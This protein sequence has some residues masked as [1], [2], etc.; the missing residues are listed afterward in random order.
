MVFTKKLSAQQLMSWF[1]GASA[2]IGCLIVTSC[3]ATPVPPSKGAEQQ[4]II[5]GTYTFG[6]LKVQKV[7]KRVKQ[8]ELPHF[9]TIATAM[10]TEK[11]A[12]LSR[13]APS[14]T[15]PKTAGPS[16]LGPSITPSATAA[17]SS[18]R[19]QRHDNRSSMATPGPVRRNM[20]DAMELARSSKSGA[21]AAKAAAAASRLAAE[22]R[23]MI[24][25]GLRTHMVNQ[26]SRL[27]Q[28][29]HALHHK[30]AQLQV[31]IPRESEIERRPRH[32]GGD[33]VH[34]SNHQ[35][36][37]LANKM[38]AVCTYYEAIVTTADPLISGG[39]VMDMS[40]KEINQRAAE[41]TALE[42]FVHGR[43]GGPANWQT[44]QKWER[45]FRKNGGKFGEG[46]KGKWER[47]LVIDEREFKLEALAF[48]K[49]EGRKRGAA[50]MRVL[51]FMKWCNSDQGLF[52]IFDKEQLRKSY[53]I[54]G[55]ITEE[56]ARLYL[57]DLGCRFQSRQTGIIPDLY[58]ARITILNA[59]V[60]VTHFLNFHLYFKIHQYLNIGLYFDGHN[61]E[62]V[63]N[64]RN[65]RFLPI[66]LEL[67]EKSYLWFS[68]KKSEC[69]DLKTAG[70][71]KDSDSRILYS[72][73][74][75]K[76]STR[77]YPQAVVSNIPA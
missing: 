37:E 53:N 39:G 40:W 27:T 32:Q 67:M 18:E 58:F 34:L 77:D 24:W 56:T 5:N 54:H 6:D 57:I 28:L 8:S 45:E 48:V 73:S 44:V 3:A 9:S 30:D 38:R 25:E 13:S 16:A 17:A 60:V 76:Q 12:E 33:D 21:A 15:P 49:T 31:Y 23:T 55:G 59:V 43:T 26:V 51:D 4:Y 62:D 50:N 35:L 74:T 66:Y 63:V 71:L 7:A 69:T 19:N 1:I 41:R 72:K 22:R 29:H 68:L 14:T 46:C 20:E 70:V 36:L 75:L 42:R 11:A 2:V 10:F 65:G 61:K 47:K 52:K 64:D